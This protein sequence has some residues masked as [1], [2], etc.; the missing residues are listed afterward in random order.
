[1]FCCATRINGS[2]LER[3]LLCEKL[4][5]GGLS[6]EGCE[7]VILT[8]SQHNETF[9]NPISLY[10]HDKVFVLFIFLW[11]YKVDSCKMI[12]YQF[13]DEMQTP[14]NTHDKT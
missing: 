8:R 7:R 4:F 10:Y 14:L 9:N 13:L 2:E 11:F 6:V 3:R 12:T 5:S 1:M